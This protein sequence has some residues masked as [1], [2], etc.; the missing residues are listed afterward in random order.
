[1]STKSSLRLI[2]WNEPYELHIYVDM[3]CDYYIEGQDGKI[4][5]SK[6]IAERI[7]KALEDMETS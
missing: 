3:G 2:N 5:V 4:R 1:M 7:S 6:E